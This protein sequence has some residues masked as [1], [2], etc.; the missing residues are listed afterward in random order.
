VID[1][2]INGPGA[3]GAACRGAGGEPALLDGVGGGGRALPRGWPAEG[4]AA[5][6]HIVAVDGRRRRSAPP[7]CRHGGGGRCRRDRADGDATAG[8]ERGIG[9]GGGELL[10]RGADEARQGR[11]H[12]VEVVLLPG[13]HALAQHVD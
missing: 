5:A 9:E 11:R 1:R 6:G 2:S 12:G 4:A 7:L 8:E 3:V 10:G 13:T